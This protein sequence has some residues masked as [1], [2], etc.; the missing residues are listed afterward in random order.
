MK[1]RV[2]TSGGCIAYEVIRT[3][4]GKAQVC[5]LPGGQVRLYAPAG[6]S[7]RD[8][9]ALVMENAEALRARMLLLD[10]PQCTPGCLPIE[11]KPHPVR[12][13]QGTPAAEVTQGEVR[14]TLPDPQDLTALHAALE[15][16]LHDLARKRIAERLAHWHARIGGAYTGVCIGDLG[17]KWGACSRDAVLAFSPLLILAQPEALDYV[18]IHELCH[19]QEFSHSA[20]F[21]NLVRAQQAECDI[22]KTWLKTHKQELMTCVEK[23]LT[24]YAE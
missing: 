4:Q 9:D 5:A 20:R 23:L 21:W 8:A 6:F 7:L 19:L 14:I 15:G 24:E 2:S 3:V 10:G 13:L 22:W 16:L 11:G 17:I 1:R 12:I 18:I